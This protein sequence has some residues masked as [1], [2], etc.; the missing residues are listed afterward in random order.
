MCSI[1]LYAH[2]LSILLL[3][4]SIFSEFSS[5]PRFCVTCFLIAKFWEFF[6]GWSENIFYVISIL[7]DVLS[8][9]HG[10][11][12][13]GLGWSFVVAM[14]T[15]PTPQA[16]KCSEMLSVQHGGLSADFWVLGL[17]MAP[18]K[19]HFNALIL[20]FPPVNILLLSLIIS[21]MVAWGWGCWSLLFWLLSF[22]LG[23]SNFSRFRGCE[24]L[25]L[26]W[27]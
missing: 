7:Q 3:W 2:F 14:V 15:V 23:L 21:S 22:H 16:S 12:W 8:L 24:L 19:D 6:P 20:Q 25:P 26:R 27:L 10:P 5:P 18:Q 9:F 13:D 17:C 1:F 4:P 11:R